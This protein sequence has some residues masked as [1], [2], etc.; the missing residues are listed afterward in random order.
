[1][2]RDF[3]YGSP[4]FLTGDTVKEIILFDLD[5]TLVNSSIGITRCVQ[6]ALMKK[7]IL[8]DDLS[9]LEC[10]IGPP[11]VESFMKFYG[12]DQ[13]E[14]WEL[15]RLFQ[16][17]YETIGMHENTAY[18]GIDR[19][20]AALKSFGKRLGVATSKPECFAGPILEELGIAHYFEHITGSLEGIGPI[21]NQRLHKHEVIEEAIRR[22][23]AEK[24]AFLMVGDREN[25][26]EGAR[27]NGIS[28]V[29]V[30]YGFGNRVE[31]R[32]AGA[33]FITDTP[34][35]MAELIKEL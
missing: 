34:E 13:A 30:L 24:D 15:V 8:I 23:G 25:D 35:T 20:L 22:F 7:G 27:I 12:F 14:S 31:L 2:I 9:N 33:D 29:G 16:D 17:R 5:G 32:L 21:E 10:F 26:I 4:F 1:M 19:A 6:Y 11:L 18:E 3:R 28:S